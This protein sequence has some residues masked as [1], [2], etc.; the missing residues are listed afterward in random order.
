MNNLRKRISRLT[1]NYDMEPVK[2]SKKASRKKFPHIEEVVYLS[3]CN[4]TFVQYCH[5]FSIR[6]NLHVCLITSS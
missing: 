4:K 5:S 2:S 3:N 6:Q 1:D